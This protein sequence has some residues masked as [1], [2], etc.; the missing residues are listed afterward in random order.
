M[1]TSR[2]F[3][4]LQRVSCV[5]GFAL[6]AAILF[7]C[8]GGGSGKNL[9]AAPGPSKPP[10]SFP[11]PRDVPIDPAL[12]ATARAELDAMLKSDFPSIRAHAIEAYRDSLPAESEGPILNQM[13][14]NNPIVRF[15]AAMAAGDL[16]L[17]AAKP[18][19][20]ARLRDPD[21]V[22]RVAI[23]YAL[24][25]L[26]DTS[27]SQALED[28]ALDFSARGTQV[29]GATAM[30]LGRLNEPTVG[31]I[32]RK[33]AA[34]SNAAVRQ[35]AE[36]ALFLHHDD[37][38][39]NAIISYTSS[40]YPDDQMFGLLVLAGA[41]EPAYRNHARAE[42]TNEEFPEVALVAARACGEMNADDGYGVAMK[43]AK[44]GD[45]R[46][47]SLAAQAFG[48]IGRTDAQPYLAE[49]L[50]VQAANP[51]DDKKVREAAEVRAAAAAAI[52]RLAKEP[53]RY[54]RSGDIIR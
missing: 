48:A 27:H 33:L 21:P 17:S 4:S 13:D 45:W 16:R 30:V 25:R 5:L 26:G 1:N 24:H 14:V 50:K 34:D 3:L 10:P 36:E 37:R 29:R 18:K 28:C 40:K 19:L 44:S 11:A 35:Q 46:R 51:N 12:V 38:G 8:G 47:Q 20:L 2:S 6:V 31:N 9:G 53:K 39:R 15:A 22:V 41:K 32:L 52:L 49:L 54:T 43:G 7:A 23:L 42:L